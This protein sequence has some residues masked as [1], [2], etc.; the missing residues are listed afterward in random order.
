[1]DPFHV[2][3]L[4]TLRTFVRSLD[5]SGAP[6]LATVAPVPSCRMLAL[7][8][9]S[10]NPPTAAH[11]LFAERALGE[12][13]DRVVFTYAVRTLG[14]DRSG[15]IP[16]DR[17]LAVRAMT[18][19][20]FDLGACSHGLYADQAEAALRAVP[21]AEVALL[22][23]SD[24]VLQ[25]F[26]DRWYD[27]REAALERLFGSASLV[28]APRSDHEDALRD[29]LEEPRNRRFRD[30]VQVLRL[31]PAVADL[32]STRVRGLLRAGADPAGLVPAGVAEMLGETRAFA[33]TVPVG[34][35]EVD[36]YALRADL[37]DLLWGSRTGDGVSIDLRAL[38][39]I[40]LSETEAGR[41]L[42]GRLA[43]GSADAADLAAAAGI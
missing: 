29:V 8:P 27:D 38:W 3:S 26:E 1:V 5:P 13:F 42:R 37:I 35:E 33:R 16:E 25:I 20:S 34:A 4:F 28:V 19:N 41:R 30:R 17:L 14:K 2:G 24:K 12:G 6:T 40:G 10:F 32:S 43:D 21:G 9:G 23:G 7:L 39:R 15:L 31:H 18:E 11:L 22:V 36:A